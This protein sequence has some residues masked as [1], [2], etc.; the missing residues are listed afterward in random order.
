[1]CFAPLAFTF[2]LL[3]CS[4]SHHAFIALP[5]MLILIQLE[6][7]WTAHPKGRVLSN[8]GPRR[9]DG[10]TKGPCISCAQTALG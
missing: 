9:G 1:M 3:L 4:F 10:Q 2:N 8:P 5:E 7:A 6:P